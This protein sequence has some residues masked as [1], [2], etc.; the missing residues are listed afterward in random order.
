MAVAFT[1]LCSSLVA[2]ATATYYTVAASTRARIDAVAL[3]NTDTVA[4]TVSVYLVSSGG[5]AGVSNIVLQSYSLAPG[6]TIRVKGAMGQVLQTG[7]KI[8]AVASVA[9]VVNIYASGVEVT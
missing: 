3:T 7:G 6:Q 8:M 5:S 2:A 9:N 4:R 1:R